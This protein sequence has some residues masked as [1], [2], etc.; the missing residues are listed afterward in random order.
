LLSAA[1]RRVFRL[2]GVHPGPDIADDAVASLAALSLPAAQ[3]AL[4]ELTQVHLVAETS[5]GR[6]SFHSLLRALAVEQANLHET[7]SARSAAIWRA[8]D[9]YVHAG[10]AADR[11]L[12]PS[13][14]AVTLPS[15]SRGVHGT[16]LADRNA[17]LAWFDAEHQVLLAVTGQA[18]R[19]GLDSHVWQLAM[20]LVTF[21][22]QRGYW[23][24][25]ESTQR[26]A[27]AAAE[28]L[29]SEAMRAVAQLE[30]GR[31]LLLLGAHDQ[32]SAQLRA[33]LELHERLGNQI[34]QARAE[35][36]LTELFERQGRYLEALRAA[37]RAHDLYLAAGHLAGTAR[38]LNNAGWCHAMLGD[39]QRAISSCQGALDLQVKVGD[40]Y[41][42]AHTWDSLG[43]AYG[44]G[45][46]LGRS[47][48]CYGKAVD[49]YGQ[50]DDRF[51]QAGTLTR[52]AESYEAIGDSMAA[53]GAWEHALSILD[54]LGHPKAGEVRAALGRLMSVSPGESQRRGLA[55]ARG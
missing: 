46:E 52:L 49:L 41:G 23:R 5:P 21:C 4:A 25:W 1:A 33:A 8:L 18:A 38:A 37:E 31:A 2:L 45:K 19:A 47:I 54:D 39:Y 12:D 22:Y 50:L 3:R 29:D 17:A 13:R 36:A 7:A 43:C 26:A 9:H 14:D 15:P 20:C 44:L 27:L 40:Q 42:Q 28:R 53:R 6:F 24:E 34:G 11:L 16:R 32:A 10:H 51:Y 55:R 35:Q 30:L 48:S